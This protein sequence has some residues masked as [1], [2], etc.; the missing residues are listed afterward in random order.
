MSTGRPAQ[1][2]GTVNNDSVYYGQPDTM[3]IYHDVCMC[4]SVLK[5][6]VTK[7]EITLSVNVLR[8]TF[9]FLKVITTTAL[10]Y[11]LLHNVYYKLACQ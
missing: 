1:A 5:A 4:V 6:G 7:T 10:T 11:N 2:V 8:L 9:N 3:L